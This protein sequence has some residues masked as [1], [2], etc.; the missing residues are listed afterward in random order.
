M[1][2]ATII[3]DYFISPMTMRTGYNI[4]NTIT[5]A[6][7][8]IVCIYAIYRYFQIK[9]IEID[10]E[11][12][13][14]AIAWTFFGSIIRVFTDAID[15]RLIYTVIEQMKQ[16]TDL[17]TQKITLP[18]YQQIEQSAILDYGIFTITPGIYVV[19]ACLFLLTFLIGKK[20]DS[21][22][23]CAKIGAVFALGAFFLVG[24]MIRYFEYAIV[25]LVVAGLSAIVISKI[26]SLK[27]IEFALPIFAHALDGM[28]TWMAIDIFGPAHEIKYFEQHVLSSAIGESTAI[29]YGLFFLVKVI[30]SLIAVFVARDEKNKNIQILALLAIA[31]MG[32]APGLRNMVRMIVGT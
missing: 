23:W 25:V 4:V 29:G 10:K 5:Y 28:A 2:V 9:K 22:Y 30:F 12:Y 17:I 13:I 1:D 20:I 8:A 32:L 6:I 11:F 14:G 31:I 18:A 7:I 24:A 26:F 15:S 19:V 3:R 21:K 27:K 16:S